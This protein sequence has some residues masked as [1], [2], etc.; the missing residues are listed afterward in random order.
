M[1][2]GGAGGGGGGHA[3]CAALESP[4]PSGSRGGIFAE[5][6]AE[7]EVWTGSRP[8]GVGGG[9]LGGGHN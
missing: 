4:E 9:G 3:P 8:G 6:W 2:L 5:R 7:E 1:Q